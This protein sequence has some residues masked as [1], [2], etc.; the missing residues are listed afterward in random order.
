M[1]E[2]LS[3]TMA[4]ELTALAPASVL[5]LGA[6]APDHLR[7]LA[8]PGSRMDLRLLPGN[9]DRPLAGLEADARFDLCLVAGLLEGRTPAPATRALARL[10]DLHAR[11]LWVLVAPGT[12]CFDDAVLTGLGLVARGR[13]PHEGRTLAWFVHDVATY[14]ATPDWLNARHWAHPERWNRDRW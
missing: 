12:P 13:R 6:D 1:V 9:T 2:G 8:A 3:A 7:R 10:R 5:G 11:A 4:R 14:K